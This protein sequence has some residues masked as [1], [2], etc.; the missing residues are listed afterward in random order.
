M[1]TRGII[2]IRRGLFFVLS[3]LLVVGHVVAQERGEGQPQFFCHSSQVNPDNDLHDTLPIVLDNYIAWIGLNGGDSDVF[4]KNRTTGEVTQITDDTIEDSDLQGDGNYIVWEVNNPLNGTWDIALHNVQS[5]ETQVFANPGEDDVDP[6]IEG[7]YVVWKWD[8]EPSTIRYYNIAT[9][10]LDTLVSGDADERYDAYEIHNGRILYQFR[11]PQND[12]TVLRFL[13]VYDLAMGDTELVSEGVA[14]TDLQYNSDIHGDMVIWEGRPVGSSLLAAEIYSY[15]LATD[16]FAQ[17]T[18]NTYFDTVSVLYGDRIAYI[19]PMGSNYELRLYDLLTASDTLLSTAIFYHTFM[20]DELVAVTSDDGIYAYNFKTNE[21][22][23]ITDEYEEQALILED[24]HVFWVGNGEGAA[25]DNDIF[26]ADCGFV[27]TI[28]TQPQDVKIA[29]GGTAMMS[30]AAAGEGNLKYQWYEGYAGD[31]TM[32]IAGATSTTYTTPPLAEDKRFWVQ[33]SNFYGEFNSLDAKVTVV[34]G[35]EILPNTSFEMD[36]DNN[37]IPDGWSAKGT[38]VNKSDKLKRNKLN[39]DGT[40]KQVAY[41]GE[42]AFMFKG[43]PD[44]TKSKLGYKLTD[45]GVITNGTVLEFSVY[46]NR[47][48]VAPGTTIGKVKISFSDGSKETLELTTPTEQAYTSVSD[49]L[50]IDLD[51]RTIEK[52]K[53]EFSTNIPSGKFII[54]AASLLVVPKAAVAVEGSLLPLP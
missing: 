51:G 31:T 16:T 50:L 53:V 37:K 41:S 34:D 29:V 48:N 32:P 19:R 38:Q 18:D 6:I 27:P 4:K 54:D 36:A 1:V 30:V 3:A 40:T 2:F 5:G 12:G 9:T 23:K 7:D 14:P 25:G 22:T 13:N 35:V 20:N 42:S 47:F 10:E 44:G 46:V 26:M 52:L 8:G 28:V 21:F 33:V 49:T 45:F 17:I 11:D 39:P 24:N 43:N 15:N